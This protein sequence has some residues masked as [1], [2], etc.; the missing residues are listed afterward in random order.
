[1]SSLLAMLAQVS[2]ALNVSL[3]EQIENT[4][5]TLATLNNEVSVR[6]RLQ[7]HALLV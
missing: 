7:V 3:I 2:A 4:P 1:M 5:G 6:V